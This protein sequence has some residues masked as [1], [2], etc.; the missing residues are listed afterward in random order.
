M[1]DEARKMIHADTT[2]PVPDKTHM[3]VFVAIKSKNS[4]VTENI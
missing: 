1:S 2:V 4:G 3:L